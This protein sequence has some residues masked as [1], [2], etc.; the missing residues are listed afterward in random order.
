VALGLQIKELADG[1]AI[2]AEVE[3]ARGLD[4]GK[5]AGHGQRR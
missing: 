4:A 5:D 1:A 3:L 2:I